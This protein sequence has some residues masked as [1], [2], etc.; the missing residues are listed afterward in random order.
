MKSALDPRHLKRQK[1]VQELFARGFHPQKVDS[2]LA[3][4][5][6]THLDSIDKTISEAA[7][8][9]A[10]DRINPVDLAI[11]RLGVYELLLAPTE[12]SKVVIDEAVELAKEFGGENSPAFVNGALGKVLVSPARTLKII[13]DNLGADQ[14]N[15]TP[16]ADL[17]ADLNA[18]DLEIA[19]L[20]ARLERDLGLE[21]EKGNKMKT[22]GDILD[23]I[24]DHKD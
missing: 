8:E 18:T 14:K 22:V 4:Q 12:P 15:V 13:A 19:D 17:R 9:F 1:A 6:L 20:L 24:E 16:E 3:Q 10:I 23:Y 21:F 11:L 7:P 5:I 2:D